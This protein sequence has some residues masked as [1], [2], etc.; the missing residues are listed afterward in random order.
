MDFSFKG[1]RVTWI[2][3]RAAD[4]GF[5]AVHV[6]GVLKEVVDTFSPILLTGQ[7]LLEKAN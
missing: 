5:A 2:G 7:V 3:S 6:D 1:S 4:H